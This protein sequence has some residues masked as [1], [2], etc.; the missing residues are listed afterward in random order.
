[1][2]QIYVCI[3]AVTVSIAF[4]IGLISGFLIIPPETADKNFYFFA[5]KIALT[6]TIVVVILI[7]IFKKMG[8]IKIE[9]RLIETIKQ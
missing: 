4:S 1:M 5:G 3:I 9:K 2:F 8:I 7:Y 6:V